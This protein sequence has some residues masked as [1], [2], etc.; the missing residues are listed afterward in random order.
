MSAD[1]PAIR[2]YPIL[3]IDDNKA[4][5][6]DFRK[7]LSPRSDDSSK[8][9]RQEALIFGEPDQAPGEFKFSVDSAY[10]GQDGLDMVREAVR[11]GNPYT[12]AFVDIR[13]PPGW[14]GV[15]TVSRIWREYPKLQVVFCSAYS[16]Y[17]W[18]SI[19]ERLEYKDRF[20]FLKKP[21]DNIEVAQ[22]AHALTEKWHLAEQVEGRLNDLTSL[23][24]EQTHELKLKN[25]QLQKDII[26]Q[27]QAEEREAGLGQILETSLN[28]IYICDAQSLQFVEVNQGARDNL[29]YSMDDLR[30]L[31]PLDICLDLTQESFAKLLKPLHKGSWEKIQFSSVHKRK[32]GTSYPVEVHL[33]ISAF[34]NAPVFVAYVLDISERVR[35]EENRL[36]LEQQLRQAQKMEAVGQ[37]AGGVAHD[38]NNMLQVI[39]GY[40]DM[41]MSGV[42]G[43]EDRNHQRLKH[44]KNAAARATGLTRQLLAFSRRQVLQ[45]QD[46]NLNDL[47]H[48]LFRMVK[49]L[50]GENIE[51][52]F[53]TGASVGTIHADPAQLEQVLIN[54]SLNARD[55]MPNGGTLKITTEDLVVSD[56][57]RKAN[58]WA[59]NER[60]VLLQLSDTGRGMSPDILQHVFEPFFTTKQVG[61]GSGLGLS[62]V[63]GII[64][65][66]G[67][68]IQVTSEVNAGTVVKI[69][70]PI[71]AK[72]DKAGSEAEQADQTQA[73]MPGKE[74][75][76]LAEDEEMVR[77]FLAQSLE[78]AGYTVLLASDGE[79]AVSEFKASRE[80]IDL[81]ILD[82]MMPKMDGAEVRRELQRMR[83][84][85]PSLF[86]SGYNEDAIHENFILDKDVTLLQKPF[87]SNQMLRKVREVLDKR[88]SRRMPQPVS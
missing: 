22:L 11:K 41:L 43:M 67:G 33:Q 40:V 38:F 2:E 60:Y 50:I 65:Q 36:K 49:R 45:P 80:E 70:L 15:E 69:Y 29:G 34:K 44:I 12:M 46:L 19:V 56:S 54:L 37:L 47:L 72:P 32:D 35:A 85:V 81:V 20:L 24:N 62:M 55:A 88:G 77:N 82:V 84:D 8:L 13:M 64:T 39:S 25:E 1:V 68:E 76:L 6:E 5:H 79:K 18:E 42:A 59:Q 21:F 14:D 66:H 28:E 57:F 78:Q 63:Y 23:V 16:D 71:V 3:V 51:V 26:K 31:T 58:E 75:I 53:T 83:M 86:I 74:T 87:T 10:Q 52:E 48:N 61:K 17:S 9:N 30:H 73:P 27:K 7:I 4:I